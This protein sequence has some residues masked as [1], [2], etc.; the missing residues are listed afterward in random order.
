[1]SSGKRWCAPEGSIPTAVQVEVTV[2][3]S[4][5]QRFRLL[6]RKAE[7]HSN[8]TPQQVVVAVV[9]LTVR[10]A[11]MAEIVLVGVVLVDTT[12]HGHC[13]VLPGQ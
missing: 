8:P 12:L 1:M 10:V 4:C 3:Q 13:L 2:V 9:W 5:G 6:W 11:P 7:Q